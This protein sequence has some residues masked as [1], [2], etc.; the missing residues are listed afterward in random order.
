VNGGAR[1]L[2]RLRAIR[3]LSEELDRSAL[4]TALASVREVE[5]AIESQEVRQ[6]EAKQ[7]AR[8]ALSTGNHGEWLLADAQ[9]EVAG[10]NCERLGVIREQRALEVPPA[11]EK[12]LE[13]RCEHEQVKQLIE[14]ARLAAE[15]EEGRRAQAASDDWFLSKR[16]RLNR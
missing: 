16:L 3:R 4:A 13:S 15:I 10:W 11:R 5:S 12:Y 2:D 14:N 6:V 1:R 7:T 8:Q 9:G